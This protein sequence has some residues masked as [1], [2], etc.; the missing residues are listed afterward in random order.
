MQRV[1]TGGSDRP[2]TDVVINSVT[3]TVARLTVGGADGATP[4]TL[5][6]RRRAASRSAPRASPMPRPTG[7]VDRRHLRRVLDRIG[8]I[9]IDSVNVLVRSQELPLFARLG[10]HPRTLIADA[11]RRRRAVRVLGARGLVT[12]RP[13]HYHLYRW[14]MRHAAPVAGVP[15]ARRTTAPTTSRR[16]T[17]HVADNGPVVAGDLKQRVG[18]KG[19]WWDWDDGKIALEALFYAGRL[20][21][22]RRPQRLRPRLRPH[23]AGA[24]RPTCWRGRRCPSTRRARSCSCSPPSTTASAR[25]RTSPTTTASEAAVPAADRR[26]GRGG[27]AGRGRR[28]RD[29]SSRRTCTPTRSLPR[30]ITARALLSP[31]DPVVW[32]R[33]RDRAAVRVPLPDRDLHAAAE[34]A[35]RLLRAA[36]PARRRARRPRRPQGRPANGARCWSRARGVSRA[37]T[38]PTSP[39]SCS[40]SCVRWRA[41]SGS[42]RVEVV[43]RGDLAQPR[44]AVSDDVAQSGSPAGGSA[45][46]SVAGDRLAGRSQRDRFGDRQRTAAAAGTRP[47][48]AAARPR[49]RRA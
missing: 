16:C 19:T 39:P 49:P 22:R 32:N 15:A 8:L 26:A 43:G 10:P 11:T 30:R 28:S 42:R 5:A 24:S 20:T 31:F 44:R 36:V 47:T 27:P 21:A 33:D 1:P 2:K 35:V 14:T 18:K 34:A 17:E 46:R 37:S 40:P 7:R 3:I 23:R 4:T 9:Q 12:C 41:G 38:R 6:S 13:T 29:G 48:A 25:S 45:Q